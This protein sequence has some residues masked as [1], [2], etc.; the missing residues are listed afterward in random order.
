MN[1][2]QGTHFWQNQV[3]IWKRIEYI[4]ILKGNAERG[5]GCRYNEGRELSMEQEPPRRKKG[6]RFPESWRGK[7]YL[8]FNVKKESKADVENRLCL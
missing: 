3:L 2:L 7:Q 6:L 5:R 8:P 4:Y 1:K